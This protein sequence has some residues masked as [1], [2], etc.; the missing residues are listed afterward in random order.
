MKAATQSQKKSPRNN[1]KNPTSSARAYSSIVVDGAERAP[2]RAMLH[3]VGFKR[4]DFK[5]SQI[6]VASTWSMVTPCNMHIDKLALEAEKGVNAAGGKAVVFGTI[7]VSDGISMGTE[8]MKYS[9]VSREVIADSIETVAG[10]E[11]FDGLVT[12][13]GCD[14]NMPGCLMAI[15]RLNRPSVFVYG[16]TILPGCLTGTM[17]GNRLN[18]ERAE[19]LKGK[20]LDVV[21]VFEAVGAHANN[22]INDRELELIEQHAIPGAGSCGGMYTANT[23]AS[24][25]EA[26]GMS[27]PNSSA[28]NAISHEKMDDCR[29]AG[30]AVLHLIKRGIRP[31]DILTREAFEN[32]ITVVIALGGSTN[33]ILHLLAIAHAAGVKLEL[34]DFTRIGKHVPVLADLKPSGRFVMSELVAIGGQTPLMKMLLEADLLHGDALTVTGKTLKENL[35][36][37]KPYPKGQQIVRPVSD[38][39]KKDSHLV[40]LRGNLA[41]EGAVAKISGKEGMKFTGTARVFEAEEFAMTAILDGTVKKGDVIVIRYEGPEGGPGMREM[42]SP[43]SAVMGKGL[44]KDVALITDGRFSG[45][46]HGFVVGHITPEAYRGG[47]IAIIR[48]GDK[49]TID[50][51]KRVINLEIPKTEIE[52]RLKKWKAPKR[53]YTR[54]VLAKYAKLVSSASEGAVTDKGL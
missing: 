47:A 16:G 8:G 21:S 31:L 20:K 54:G 14:K 25:I 11:G 19:Q 4:E 29:R 38:P 32:A 1:S 48:N 27:L 23:M 18:K 26:L 30:A 7:T 41:H 13:G 10:C 49:I 40:I 33:A 3:A 50:A 35:K 6:G 22:K 43:T 46:S 28:Q 15:A 17:I 42:L 39:I 34:D 2:S 12:I 45:G 53:R 52:A 51:E 37:V 9:L 5:K 44:G 36:L 24:A